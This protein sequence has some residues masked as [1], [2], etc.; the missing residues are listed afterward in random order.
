MKLEEKMSSCCA[1]LRRDKR[2]LSVCLIQFWI[3]TLRFWTNAD[4]I[5]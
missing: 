4:L 5:H 1:F 2:Q 3:D